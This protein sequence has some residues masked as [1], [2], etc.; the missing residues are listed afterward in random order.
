M[1]GR[2]RQTR[3]AKKLLPVQAPQ[4]RV[5]QQIH[6][7][8]QLTDQARVLDDSVS[9]DSERSSSTL[10]PQYLDPTLGPNSDYGSPGGQ[11]LRP[12]NSGT[13]SLETSNHEFNSNV[14]DQGEVEDML[15]QYCKD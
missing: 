14:T 2:H 15:I 12:S 9:P 7:W 6:F 11:L 4:K 10:S 8:E 3:S 5:E 13:T 1:R